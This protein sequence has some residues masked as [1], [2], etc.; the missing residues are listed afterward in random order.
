MTYTSSHRNE[1]KSVGRLGPSRVLN[2][3]LPMGSASVLIT[4]T[5]RPWMLHVMCVLVFRFDSGET[6]N[7]F[8]WFVAIFSHPL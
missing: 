8:L 2:Q 4:Q 1:R 7:S 5:D 6:K 3:L